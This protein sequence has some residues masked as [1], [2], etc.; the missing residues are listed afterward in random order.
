MRKK[1]HAP[2]AETASLDGDM[3][4]VRA[5]SQFASLGLEPGRLARVPASLVAQLKARAIVD[6]HPDAVAAA[7]AL[8]PAVEA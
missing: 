1:S 5:L 4:E 7:R 2:G 3:V 6:D 8:E